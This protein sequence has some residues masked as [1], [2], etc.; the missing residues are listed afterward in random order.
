MLFN[1]LRLGFLVLPERLVGAFE[2][3]RSFIDRHPPTLDRA[4][5]A[6]FIAEGHFGHHVRRMRQ[7]YAERASVLQEAERKHLRGSV[8]IVAPAAGMRTIGWLKTRSTDNEI[9]QRGWSLGLDLTALSEFIM[10][11]SHPTALILGFAGCN[12]G[13]LRRGVNV[14]AGAIES[15]G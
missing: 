12:A 11:H 1:A 4:V 8:D 10:R 15:A 5:L 14:L 3:I 6:E 7:T 2:A 9:A 13:E